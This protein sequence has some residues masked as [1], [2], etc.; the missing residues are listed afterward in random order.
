MVLVLSWKA[1]KI[2]MLCEAV[3]QWITP[4]KYAVL[5]DVMSLCLDTMALNKHNC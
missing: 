4:V 5:F 1:L 2:S 3:Q